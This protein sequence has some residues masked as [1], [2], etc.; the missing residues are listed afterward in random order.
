MPGPPE[1]YVSST[2]VHD[3][4]AAVVAAIDGPA[5]VYNIVDDV[6][7]TRREYAAAFAAA[8]GLG[9]LIN[10]PSWMARA[11]GGRGAGALT[12]SQRVSNARAKAAL[13]WAPQYVDARQGW[14]A[15][16]AERQAGARHGEGGTG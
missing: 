3:A 10:A 2:H 5:G 9:H 1:A 11:V 13:G 8:F 15:V 7:L 12:R 14:V 6:P 4:A 16:A